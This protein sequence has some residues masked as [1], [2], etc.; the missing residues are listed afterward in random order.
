MITSKAVEKSWQYER[1]SDENDN[2]KHNDGLG[3]DGE[4]R[5]H[6][7]KRPQSSQDIAGVGSKRAEQKRRLRLH[8]DVGGNAGRSKDGRRVCPMRGGIGFLLSDF[9]QA[10]IADCPTIGIM[11]ESR[12]G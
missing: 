12:R 9:F 3:Q 11:E 8:H 1:Q 5:I 10:A 2:A 4:G 7:R 6:A